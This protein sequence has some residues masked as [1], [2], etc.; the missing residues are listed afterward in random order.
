MPKIFIS[1]RRAD[2]RKDAG[3]IHDRLVQAF[4]VE[5][6]FMDVNNDNIPI[7]K[8]FRGIL[9]ESVAN[10]DVLLAL[11]GKSWLN[12]MDEQGARRLDNP[13]DFV[14]IEI[15]SALRR[16]SCLVIP[17]TV[18]GTFPPASKDLPDTLRELAF[19]N[20]SN[21]RDDPDFHPDVDKII[22]ALQKEYQTPSGDPAPQFGTLPAA[23]PLPP[24]S[25]NV[26]EA[27][28]RYHAAFDARDW[29][30]A[31]AVLNEIRGSGA[32][33]PRAFKIDEHE[34]DIWTEIEAEEREQEYSVLRRM[35][36]AK[37]PNAARIWSALQTFWET[38][39][40]Y[41]PDELT[42]FKPIPVVQ[43]PPPVLE[44]R[45]QSIVPL[46]SPPPPEQPPARTKSRSIGL[47]PAPF[48]WMDIP[49]GKV[50][51]QEGGYVLKGG[52]TFDVPAFQIAK[53]PITNA[54]YGK[55]IEAGGYREKRWW[56]EAGWQMRE[57]EKWIEPRFWSDEKWKGALQPVVGVSWYESVAFCLWMREMSGEKI[58]LPTEQQWQ[59][60][61]Q[62]DDGRAYP[63][64]NEWDG[65]R[66]NS[67][68]KP[69]D[70]VQTTPV[71]QYEGKDKGDSPYG[72]VDMAGNVW[73]WCVTDYINGI[74]E[75]NSNV[76]VCV[77]RGS[78][79]FDDL[80]DFFRADYR[81]R[82]RP[83]SWYYYWGF[84]LALS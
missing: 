79:W 30:A 65:S 73:E 33:L 83:H 44:T 63:W 78:S 76:E 23:A 71:T 77:L 38:Y 66:C 41:D 31:R 8:D 20:A 80:A 18:D 48:A 3:R 55:F 43:I 69:F 2:S 40:E 17:V 70:S 24:P 13:N 75:I 14:R 1:Y 37:Q 52:Q 61:A 57:A 42:R 54:Q 64:G 58:M 47:M 7:G 10:C 39:P 15:E 74:Q 84:R 22:R 25:Y 6:V 28:D 34:K 67:S 60:A 32:K 72:V 68:V 50:R 29:D 4:G 51:L 36:Q 82:N 59:R 21:V 11:I 9:R 45:A 49:A 62:G 53:Y 19:K 35:A 46:Q 5:N 81:N 26:Y 12:I 16:D 56:T 27:I